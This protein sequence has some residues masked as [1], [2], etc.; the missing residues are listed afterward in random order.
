MRG[1]RKSILE[2]LAVVGV[3]AFPTATLVGG[4]P[5]SASKADH[6]LPVLWELDTGG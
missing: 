6:D 2:G 4:G 5:D 3:L 1:L